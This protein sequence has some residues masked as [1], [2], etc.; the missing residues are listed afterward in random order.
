M[1]IGLVG[2]RTKQAVKAMI[3]SLLADLPVHTFTC[4]KEKEF[5][6]HE[7]IAR[8]LDAEVYFAHPYA[9]WERGTNE[10]TN[11]LIRQYLPKNT[12]FCK[13]IKADIHFAENRL[14]NRPRKCLSFMRPVVF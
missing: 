13:L 14:N 3:I 10:K 7:E 8:V 12:D 4:D 1:Y 6:D 9:S 11:G 2:W 5:A